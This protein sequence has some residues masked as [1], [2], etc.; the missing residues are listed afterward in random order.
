M[1]AAIAAVG[2]PA[3]MVS[4]DNLVVTT[5]LP[6][7]RTAFDA[8]TSDLQWIVD[9]Y[10]LPYAALL[11]TAA[12]LG[13]RFG[14][15][16]IFIAAIGVF[17][18]ASAGCALAGTVGELK[19]ARA[20]QGASG[21]FVMTL[22][23]ALLAA[24]VPAGRRPLAIALW[25]GFT[26]LGV[27]IG[28][29]LGGAVVEG[30][31][32]TWIF[33][34]N[35]PVGLVAMV[36]AGRLLSESRGAARRID[37]AGIALLTGS[38]FVLVWGVVEAPTHGWSS[39]RVLLTLAGGAAIFALFLGWQARGKD[40]MLPLRLFRSRVFSVINTLSFSLNIGV[41]GSIF[42]LAQFF[43]VVQGASP[44]Q[45]GLRTLPCSLVPLFVGPATGLLM[46][47]WGAARLVLAGQVMVAV[48]LV[49]MASAF[50][51]EV[52]FGW[53]FGPFL[54]AGI[55]LGLSYP[56]ISAI[57][58]E[59]VPEGER[60]VA[61]GVNN[62]A[63]ELGVAVGVAMLV[64]IFATQGGYTPATFVDGL[65]PALFTASVIVAAGAALTGLLPGF[66]ARSR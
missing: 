22:S 9:A 11:L 48:S 57:A 23:L 60:A 55:G 54:L 8:S 38:I 7:M 33:W 62:T 10:T 28:P 61:A 34:L 2:L 43:Q 50:S 51:A 14:R 17:T 30:L 58:L 5:A 56:P 39:P 13:D 64:S 25:S 45:A 32:W 16:L 27:A 52:A 26:G 1:K 19:V 29:V 46:A 49:W 63:R 31:H 24:A 65:N 12:A 35:V 6:A 15:R 18:L 3:F 21:A 44:L 66:R 47:R 20:V 42:L 59:A 53:L 37:L 40:P 36:L 41:Y 4:L